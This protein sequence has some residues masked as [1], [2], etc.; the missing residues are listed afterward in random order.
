LLRTPGKPPGAA[1][2]ADAELLGS[3]LLFLPVLEP[4]LLAQQWRW[5]AVGPAPVGVGA[6]AA[7]RRFALVHWPIK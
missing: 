7:G 6:W 4:F 2:H 5:S 3:P 1:L